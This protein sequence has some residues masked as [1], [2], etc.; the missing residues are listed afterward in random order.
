[1]PVFNEDQDLVAGIIR[2]LDAPGC[3]G[4]WSPEERLDGFGFNALSNPERRR[5]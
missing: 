5:R 1:M 3:D 2:F 4:G